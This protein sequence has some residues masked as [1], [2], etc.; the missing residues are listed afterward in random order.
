MLSDLEIAQSAEIKPITEIAH[1]MG[2]VDDDLDMYGKYK[3]KISLDVL[4]KFADKP[5]GF[6]VDVTAITPTPLGEGKTTTTVGLGMALN[7]V[8]Q[9]TAICLR[10]PSLG[11]FFSGQNLGMYAPL[12]WL[13]YWLGSAFS[14]QDAWG[15]H[16][17]GVVLHTVNSVLVFSLLRQLT[18]GHWSAFAAGLPGW[19]CR[20]SCR[21]SSIR[22]C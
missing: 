16:L 1:A 12:T 2:L 18:G 22:R 19:R 8:G 10:Q 20:C 9:K 21:M 15:Y 6:Y 5:N 14:G 3:A 13:A 11:K 4:K 7:R 17:L